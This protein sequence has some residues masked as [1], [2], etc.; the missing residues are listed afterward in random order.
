[1]IKLI[2]FYADWCGPCQAMKPV[3]EKVMPEFSGKIELEK[4]DVDK[5]PEKAQEFGVMGIPAMVL[6]KDDKEVDRK[7][8]M[9]PEPAFK[10][11]LQGHLL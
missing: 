11:W 7:V 3:F 1:M 8:G 5:N 9:L 2:D 6:I 4:I 10:Q